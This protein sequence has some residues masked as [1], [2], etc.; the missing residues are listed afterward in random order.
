VDY[1]GTDLD[2]PNP[3]FGG[4]PYAAGMFSSLDIMRFAPAAAFQPTS[5]FSI[6]FAPIREKH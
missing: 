3:N 5:N 4:F 2:K 6:G 1:R